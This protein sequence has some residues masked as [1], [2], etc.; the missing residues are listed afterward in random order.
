MSLFAKIASIFKEEEEIKEVAPAVREEVRPTHAE[1]GQELLDY[2]QA[3]F[4]EAGYEFVE[5]DINTMKEI[6]KYSKQIIITPVN[7]KKVIV[8]NLVMAYIKTIIKTFNTNY[9]VKTLDNKDFN[10]NIIGYSNV[11]NK[12]NIATEDFLQPVIDELNKQNE[13]LSKCRIV[14]VN[15]KQQTLLLIAL[16]NTSAEAPRTFKVEEVL[17]KYGK[18]FIKILDFKGYK[19]VDPSMKA[20]EDF[21]KEVVY[22]EYKQK[23][24]QKI[25]KTDKETVLRL[26]NAKH[27][28]T[29][30]ETHL[31]K[32]NLSLALLF[33]GRKDP[34]VRIK[35]TNTS[36]ID[37][38]LGYIE[39]VG[40]IN[41]VYNQKSNLSMIQIASSNE[42]KQDLVKSGYS[43]H[44]VTILTQLLPY[45]L[46]RHNE[47]K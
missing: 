25:V 42:F 33:E 46:N 38:G 22:T 47:K 12:M 3:K 13:L 21:L 35:R 18:E 1:Y 14:K 32:V 44:Q 39:L 27:L 15:Q 24:E 20:L 45:S 41:K 29:K 23:V 30:G 10:H 2:V 43:E 8:R 37:I 17:E 6:V 9:T 16:K 28:L 4:E 31:S 11:I 5:T 36:Y 34:V 40:A 7:E 19:T 26:A